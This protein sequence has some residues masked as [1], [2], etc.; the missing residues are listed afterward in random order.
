MLDILGPLQTIACRISLQQLIRKDSGGVAL[1]F[2]T[3]QAREPVLT[4]ES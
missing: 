4:S 2:Q 3:L 1:L